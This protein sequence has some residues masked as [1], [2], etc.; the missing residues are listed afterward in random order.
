MF[1]THPVFCYRMKN[2]VFRL[3]SYVIEML[4]NCKNASYTS[5]GSKLFKAEI[6]TGVYKHRH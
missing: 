6:T 2:Y 3:F 1:L 5:V 4:R